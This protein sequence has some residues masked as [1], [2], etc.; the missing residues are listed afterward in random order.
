MA[1]EFDGFQS[2]FSPGGVQGKLKFLLRFGSLYRYSF[3][4]YT[5]IDILAVLVINNRKFVSKPV[6]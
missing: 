5:H 6:I 3:I 2:P 4:L 1:T